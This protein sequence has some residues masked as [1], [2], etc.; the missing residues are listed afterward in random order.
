M[1]N[2]DHDADPFADLQSDTDL[3]RAAPAARKP[4][5]QFPCQSCAGTGIYR[6]VS[7]HQPESRCFACGGKGYFKTSHG[8]RLKARA[9]AAARKRGKVETAAA[10]FDETHPGLAAFLRGAASWSPFA[11]DLSA[12]LTKYSALTERQANAALNMRAKCEARKAERDAA[13]KAA[14]PVDLA[15]IKTMFEKARES[16]LKRPTYRANGL[17]IT[18]APMHGSR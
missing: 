7:L 1:N 2:P 15:P 16:G 12:A 14:P 5:P 18:A 8:D 13:A 11:A 6:G 10:V 4:E 3:S 17:V 9:K